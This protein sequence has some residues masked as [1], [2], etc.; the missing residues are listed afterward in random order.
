MAL[1]RPLYYTDSGN[2]KEMNDEE[3]GDLHAEAKKFY[4]NNPPVALTVVNSG[5]NLGGISQSMMIA[6]ANRSNRR[7]FAN[8]TSSLGS[9]SVETTYFDRIQQTLQPAPFPG[10]NFDL[11]SLKNQLGTNWPVYYNDSGNFEP[12]TDSDFLDTF[13]NPVLQELGLTNQD[14]LYVIGESAGVVSGRY[15]KV[16]NTA[17]YTDKVANVA[18]YAADASA[19][20]GRRQSITIQNWYLWKLKTGRTGQV[21]TNV[22]YRDS[23]YNRPVLGVGFQVDLEKVPGGNY[24]HTFRARGSGYVVSDNFIVSGDILGG[25]TP[26]NDWAYYVNSIDSFGGVTSL[27]PNNLKNGIGNYYRQPLTHTDSAQTPAGVHLRSMKKTDL[28]TMINTAMTHQAVTQRGQRVRF[29]WNS[30]GQVGTTIIDNR[31]VG[32]A[33]TRYN[34]GPGNNDTYHSQRVPTGGTQQIVA[35]HFLGVKIL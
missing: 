6:S 32:T 12:F 16:S 14:P 29:A 23:A 19:N 10:S 4:L 15:T 7:S 27:L 35:T 22:T 28:E 11:T 20:V 21:F 34:T 25:D 3:L 18:K 33:N 31:M 9:R 2:I 17:I 24:I 1:R 5:G 30:G 26:E 8:N 13:A